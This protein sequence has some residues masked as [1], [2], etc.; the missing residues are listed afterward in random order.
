MPADS[1]TKN[2]ISVRFFSGR[3]FS[4][5][6]ACLIA[7]FLL[8]SLL[9][10][11]YTLLYCPSEITAQQ[12]GQMSSVESVGTASLR[13]VKTSWGVDHIRAGSIDPE[14]K[15][16]GVKIA[17]LDTGIDLDHPA[18]RVAGDVSFVPGTSSGDDDN[19]HGTM[20]AG[21]IG[22]INSGNGMVGVAPEA[23]L[24][25]VKVI[26]PNGIGDTDSI[27]EGIEWCI[28]NKM[29][30]LNLSFG[31]AHRLPSSVVEVMQ[32]AYAAG[33]LI[34]AGAGND[35]QSDKS[36]SIW[37]P[38]QYESVIAVGSIS[39]DAARLPFSSI[40]P[41]LELMAPGSDIIS[42]NNHGTYSLA[43]GSSFSAPFVSGVAALV[44][45]AGIDNNQEVR[46]ILD[47]SAKD[48]G[49]PGKDSQYGYGLVDAQKALSLV[50]DS[51]YPSIAR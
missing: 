27:V 16:R 46:G 8:L 12:E 45:S 11:I 35:G 21:I 37:Y 43:N 17:I 15:G 22:A 13:P 34:V 2:I 38:A 47:D 7:I 48:L 1:Q 23:S 9:S 42:C 51:L 39:R 49:L 31:D 14:N 41:K 44:L 36:D 25:S 30:I 4:S 28:D 18:L 19:G 26:G 32:R 29:Q 33:I 3:Y 20:V 40:G 5:R 50:T 24:Y 6:F 10:L